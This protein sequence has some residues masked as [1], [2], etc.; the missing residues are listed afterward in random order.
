[1][2]VANYTTEKQLFTQKTPSK[3]TFRQNTE[4]IAKEPRKQ[5]GTLCI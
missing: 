5:L 1:M 2:F 3:N 4:H